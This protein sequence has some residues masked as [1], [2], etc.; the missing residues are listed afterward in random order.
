MT[1]YVCSLSRLESMVAHT[2]ARSVVSLTTGKTPLP[3]LARIEPANRLIL[4]F[5]DI[6]EPTEGLI[7]PSA[8]H[9]S[10]LIDF[11]RRWDRAA[12]LLIHCW[13]GISR[14]TAGAFITACVQFPDHDEVRIAQALRRSSP[15]AT[16]NPRMVALADE[17]LGRQG[18]MVRAIAAIG[19]GRDAME[20]VPFCLKLD[21][22]L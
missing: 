1:I 20:G 11:A 3:D 13:A 8:E 15:F 2:S 10:A 21:E 7:L 22:A 18:R 16:P 17:Q 19:R 5:N 12:P 6:V 9:V 4:T 14:S